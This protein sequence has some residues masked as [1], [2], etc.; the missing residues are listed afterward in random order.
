MALRIDLMRTL[1]ILL[2]L[3]AASLVL[4]TACGDTDGDA[5][6]SGMQIMASF[7]PLEWVSQRVVGERADVTSMTP[8]GAEPHDLELSPR[9]VAEM[10]EADLVV[11][12][13]GFQPAVDEAVA[14]AQ[15]TVA[16]DAA[17]LTSLDL[18]ATDDGHAHGAEEHAEEAGAADPHFWLDPMRLAEVGDALA[19]RMAELDPDGTE[20]YEQNAADLR[21]DLEALDEE[22]TAGLG[23]CRSTDLVTSHQAFGYLAER[24]GFTQVGISGL[25][26]EEEPSPAELAEVT[27]FVSDND[28]S[29]IYFETLVSPD[30]AQTVAD[31]AGVSTATLDPL[32]GLTEESAGD[33]YLEVMRVNLAT[34]REGQ[35]CT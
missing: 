4:A 13:S 25:S 35:S 30:V 24:Y 18:E 29:T 12:L 1:R 16:V 17:E 23:N 7:Y 22:M 3:G 26:P 10:T 6:A 14:V 34:L 21:A 31:E 11:Y 28:V 2:A 27:D 33:D 32:E 20:D 19:D 9:D 5:S 8:P 15:D